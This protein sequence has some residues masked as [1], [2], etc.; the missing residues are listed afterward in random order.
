MK[1]RKLLNQAV[2]QHSELDF[3]INQYLKG[4]LQDELQGRVKQVWKGQGVSTHVCSPFVGQLLEAFWEFCKKELTYG[5]YGL[6]PDNGISIT[7]LWLRYFM[8]KNYNERWSWK[9]KS[10]VVIEKGER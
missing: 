8:F 3:L 6:L 10:W 2:H 1:T 4:R 9:K 5:V 7:Q